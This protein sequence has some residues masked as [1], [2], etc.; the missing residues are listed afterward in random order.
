VG[1]FTHKTV[2]H[3][4]KVCPLACAARERVESEVV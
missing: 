4:P 3:R 1:A 2:M